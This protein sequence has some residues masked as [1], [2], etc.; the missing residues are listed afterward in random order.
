MIDYYTHFWKR[1]CFICQ[2]LLKQTVTKNYVQ[3][4]YTKIASDVL[5]KLTSFDRIL[6]CVPGIVAFTK[7][8][9]R[10]G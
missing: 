8:K 10:N 3:H 5:V 9:T 2:P 1:T 4:F 6:L 7:W